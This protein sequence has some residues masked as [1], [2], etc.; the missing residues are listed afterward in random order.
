MLT[1]NILHYIPQRPPFVFIDG[2]VFLSDDGSFSTIYT[3]KE[4]TPLSDEELFSEAGLLE[5][6]A[7]SIAAHIGYTTV[8]EVRIGVIGAIKHFEIF[9]LPKAGDTI[10]CNLKIINK[11]FD[12]TLVEAQIHLEEKII[13][14]GEIKVALQ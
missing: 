10:Y 8:G 14:Q 11:I 4:E 7:Q 2:I 9:K 13:A 1:T 3:V 6:V 5:F 12:I